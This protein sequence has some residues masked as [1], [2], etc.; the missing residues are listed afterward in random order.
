MIKE[1][2]PD[3]PDIACALRTGYPEPVAFPRCPVCGE[4]TDV[5]FRN[6]RSGEILGCDNC[7]EERDAW[8]EARY[9]I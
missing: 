4:E 8:E 1:Q 7:I 6:C 2:I 9:A 5:F 3:H